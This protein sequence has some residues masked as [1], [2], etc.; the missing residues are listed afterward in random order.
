[1]HASGFGGMHAETDE[2]LVFSDKLDPPLETAE[3]CFEGKKY[4]NSIFKNQYTSLY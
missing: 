3:D 2:N 4:Y 1:M